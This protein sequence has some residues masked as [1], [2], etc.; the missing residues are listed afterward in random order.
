[1]GKLTRDNS[2]SRF[3]SNTP[4]PANEGLPELQNSGTSLQQVPVQFSISNGDVPSIQRTKEITDKMAPAPTTAI[5]GNL[6][7]PPVVDEVLN[8]TGK[9]LDPE[10]RSNMESRFAYDFSK[11]KIHD[12]DLAAKSARSINAMAY[13][14]GNNIV[15][16]SGQYNSQSDSG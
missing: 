3:K 2:F 1:M 4:R 6:T 14:S 7:T 9:S 11:V 12:D 16:N 8:S 5:S 15:F 10:T 13:T